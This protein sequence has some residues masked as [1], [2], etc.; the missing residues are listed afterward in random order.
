MSPS[1]INPN[2]TMQIPSDAMAPAGAPAQPEPERMPW[3]A[4]SVLLTVPGYEWLAPELLADKTVRQLGPGQLD[5]KGHNISEFF[6]LVNVGTVLFYPPGG[7]SNARPWI[8]HTGNVNGIVAPTLTYI[9]SGHSSV[10]RASARVCDVCSCL[11][12]LLGF[13]CVHCSKLTHW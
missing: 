10:R 6:V 2:L 4:A 7:P 11:W 12:R 5:Q 8:M 13:V 1:Q 3:I 9:P